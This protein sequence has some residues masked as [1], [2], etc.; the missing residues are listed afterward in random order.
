MAGGGTSPRRPQNRRSVQTLQFGSQVTR[1]GCEGVDAPPLPLRLGDI[2]DLC[3]T[4]L[5][6]LSQ[7]RWR[8]LGS[9]D[10]EPWSSR[11]HT[12]HPP[13]TPGHKPCPLGPA[14][15]LTWLGR[16][17]G[18]TLCAQPKGP[19]RAACGTGSPSEAQAADL[20]APNPLSREQEGSQCWAIPGHRV[21]LAS[22]RLS[23]FHATKAGLSAH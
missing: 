13:A 8:Q 23:H 1:A 15:G 18:R 17:Q 21:S 2:R 4:R 20:G 3:S 11:P 19:G 5:L 22:Q 6:G 7:D 14:P 16:E 9:G 12:P 10:R